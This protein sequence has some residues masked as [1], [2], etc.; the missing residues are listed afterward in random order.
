MHLVGSLSSPYVH[1]GR[2]QEIKTVVMSTV[3][4][5]IAELLVKIQN[6]KM[7]VNMNG[8]LIERTQ[9]AVFSG[10][11]RPDNLTATILTTVLDAVCETHPK[12]VH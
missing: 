6:I 1:N 9:C 11:D 3:V 10:S 7:Y 8:I 2:S 5:W 4:I 12:S